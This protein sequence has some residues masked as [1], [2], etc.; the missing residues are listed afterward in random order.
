MLL[1]VL[2]TASGGRRL[3][4]WLQ[5]P[6]KNREEIQNRYNQVEYWNHSLEKLKQVRKILSGLRDIE[7]GLAKIAGSQVKVQ[8]LVMLGQT[9]KR[10]FIVKFF[11]F[12]NSSPC[13]Q[14]SL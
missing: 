7:R 4:Q 1:T 3:R 5:F 8:D 10:S 6:L 12:E 9:L 13:L 14:I 2:K 11:W